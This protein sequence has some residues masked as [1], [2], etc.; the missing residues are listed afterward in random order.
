MPVWIKSAELIYLDSYHAFLFRGMFSQ[1]GSPCEVDSLYSHAGRSRPPLSYTLIKVEPHQNEKFHLSFG[2]K[3]GTEDKNII[4]L[5]YVPE[6]KSIRCEEISS[7][8]VSSTA[9]GNLQR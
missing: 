5:L 8:T 4:I 7:T 6:E 1:K 3:E 2:L 9:A